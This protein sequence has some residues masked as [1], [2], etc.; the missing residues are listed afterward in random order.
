M[1][2]FLGAKKTANVLQQPEEMEGVGGRGDKVEVFVEGPG[3]VVLGVD[4]KSAN[5]GNLGGLESAQHG[6]FQQPGAK[7]L[8][9]E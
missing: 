1:A 4:G 5:S 6:V 3:P 7:P 8:A 9:L 2:W